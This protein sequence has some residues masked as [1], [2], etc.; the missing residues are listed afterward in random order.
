VALQISTDTDFSF[1]FVPKT[2]GTFFEAGANDGVYISNTLWLELHKEWTG[3][4]VEPIQD[5]YEEALLK[6]RRAAYLNACVSPYP[7]P[8]QVRTFTEPTTYLLV[9]RAEY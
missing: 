4:L 7:F 2:H 8:Y 3:L 9:A 6:R 1:M 5:L